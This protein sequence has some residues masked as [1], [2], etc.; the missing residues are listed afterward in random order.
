[1]QGL[2]GYMT[3]PNHQGIQKQVDL[4]E[5]GVRLWCRI[6]LSCR[7]M[8]HTSASRSLNR[9]GQHKQTSPLRLQDGDE[10]RNL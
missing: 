6:A 9:A 4:L 1:M 8:V 7:E 5:A 3:M 10:F 2:W